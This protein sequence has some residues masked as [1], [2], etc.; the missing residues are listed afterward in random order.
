MKKEE[1]SKDSRKTY[2]LKQRSLRFILI[3]GVFYKRSLSRPLLKCLGPKQSNYVLREIHEG[4]CRNQ[5]GS[6]F[7]AWK[8]LLAGY[9]WPTMQKDALTIVIS[10]LEVTN[11]SLV[12]S[13]KTRLGNAK[14]NW[15]EELP[16]MLWS[17]MTTPKIGTG[18][19][20]FSLVYGNK[21]VLLA[22]IDE[23]T[24]RVMF[25]DDQ[26]DERRTA[27]LDFLEE[28]REAA[29]IRMEAYKRH[30]ARSYNRKVIQ[31]S[32][33]VG[34][35]VWKKIQD[36]D[37]GKLDPRWEGPFKVVEKLSSG[38]YYF[39]DLLGKKLKRPWNAYHLRKY[40]A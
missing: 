24:S 21:A 36:V 11:R 2:R 14:G 16:S 23:K 19:T 32:F 6:Y 18:E 12:Q 31:R 29:A 34:D 26:N 9:F 28:K 37:V 35:L 8:I 4:C 7:L 38:A 17:Y 15:V 30:K 39:E 20:P 25:Y 40:Y 3:N 22:E 27:D 5:L 13:L 10:C 1:L 33:Q